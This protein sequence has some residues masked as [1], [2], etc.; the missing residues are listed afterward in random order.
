V[1]YIT[2]ES[3]FS[4]NIYNTIGKLIY[5]AANSEGEL[6]FDMSALEGGVYLVQ[7]IQNGIFSS[8]KLI[9]K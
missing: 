2:S 1:L 3:E 4:V 6:T 8:Q 7:T 9:K 5:T